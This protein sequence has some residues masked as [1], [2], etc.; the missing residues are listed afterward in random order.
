MPNIDWLAVEAEVTGLLQ[1]LIRI[2]T[3]NPP[4]HETAAARYIASRLEVDGYKATITESEPGRGNVTTCLV[5][6]G[7]PALLLLGHTDVVPVEPEMWSVPPFSGELKDGHVWG[8]GALDMKNMVAAELMV[9][10][11]LKRC[12]I[13]L[14]RDVLYGATADEE[15]GKGNHGPGWL[16]DHHPEL[17]DAPA[18]LTEG[19][20]HDLTIGE[21]RFYTCQVGQKGICRLRVCMRG[22]P[23]HGSI[24]RDDNAAVKLCASLVALL[25]AQLP[26]HPSAGLTTFLEGAARDQP[27]SLAADLLAIADPKQSAQALARLDMDTEFKAQLGSL[28][29]NTASV[30]VLEAGSKINVIPSEATAFIDGRLAPGQDDESFL[31]ELRSLVGE[32]LEIEVE[33][34]S[35][36]LEASADHP[37]F[38]TIES[39]MERNDP[40]VPVLPSLSTGGTDAKHIVPRR[41]GTEVFGFLPYRQSPGEE[42]MNLIHGH[43]ERTSVANLVF[44]TRVLFEIVCDYGGVSPG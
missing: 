43:D 6:G 11:L 35:P 21:R 1:D 39:V 4:G 42:E 10:L 31:R 20:G 22:T 2:D 34:Y 23:G 3:T 44:A 15:A 5:G 16:L 41:P 17:I 36:P 30:T 32:Q 18:I 40:G 13:E 8:R 27:A 26:L 25:G 9:M 29:R 38:R 24:P 14:N 19:G 7:E 37:L 28:L 12:S 33:Q